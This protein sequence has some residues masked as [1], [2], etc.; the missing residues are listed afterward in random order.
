MSSIM[1][2]ARCK[3]RLILQLV[4]FVFLA[5]SQSLVAQTQASEAKPQPAA[6]PKQKQAAETPS[7]DLSPLEWMGGTW[8]MEKGGKITE[9]HWRPIQGSFILGS[10]HTF[11]AKQSYF[12]EYLRIVSHQ[13]KITYFAMPA[14]RNETAFEM[15]RSDDR[16]VDF[17]NPNHDYPQRI[18]YEKTDEGMTATISLLDGKRAT[19]FEFKKKGTE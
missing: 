7:N 5:G 15:A 13:E 3:L 18:R 9:E 8:V 11:D 16:S 6:E 17:E 1:R 10:S 2:S 19:K 12:F 14:G 4:L